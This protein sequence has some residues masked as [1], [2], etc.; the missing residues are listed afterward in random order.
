MI[1][2][3]NI[4]F[5]NNIPAEIQD[6]YIEILEAWCYTNLKNEE[7]TEIY[8]KDYYISPETISF[9]TIFNKNKRKSESFCDIFI[10]LPLLFKVF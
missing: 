3:E 8:I 4:Y 7:I 1:T 10:K 6:A 5:S 9:A 2:E